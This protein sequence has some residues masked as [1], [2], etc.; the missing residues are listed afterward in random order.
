[1]FQCHVCGFSEAA[2]ELVSEVFYIDGKPILVEKI[3]A[4]VCGRCSEPTFS[5]ETTE[6]IRRM[7][8]GGARPLRTVHMDV[9]AYQ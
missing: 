4:Q 6:K 3:P 9:F 1:M 8:H 5:R 7:V 2:Q